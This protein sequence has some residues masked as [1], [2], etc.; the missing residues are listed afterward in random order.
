MEHLRLEC[1]KLSIQEALSGDRSPFDG[2]PKTYERYVQIIYDRA[3]MLLAWV[4]RKDDEPEAEYE[5]L[6]MAT[7]DER[8]NN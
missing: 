3:E 1:L 7:V 5:K 2:D 6:P 8:G 4:T